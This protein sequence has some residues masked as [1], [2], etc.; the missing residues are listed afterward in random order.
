M[1][2]KNLV[3]CQSCGALKGP[4]FLYRSSKH[5]KACRECCLQDIKEWK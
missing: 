5:K 2:R 1:I 3:K 4:Y